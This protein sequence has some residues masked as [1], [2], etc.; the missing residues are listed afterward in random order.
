M[1]EVLT[2]LA[3]SDAARL[4]AEVEAALERQRRR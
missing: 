2:D 4:A 3:A 1:A